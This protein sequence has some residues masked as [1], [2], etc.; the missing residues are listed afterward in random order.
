MAINAGHALPDVQPIF[1]AISD[2]PYVPY[3]EGTEALQSRFTGRGECGGVQRDMHAVP[4]V[5]AQGSLSR[6][7]EGC[8]KMRLL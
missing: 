2:G 8:L 3:K 6:S 5:C 1:C 7:V 4:T